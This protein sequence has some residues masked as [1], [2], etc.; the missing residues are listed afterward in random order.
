MM[1][2]AKTALWILRIYND[3]TLDM[4]FISPVKQ[5]S[6]NFKDSC[7]RSE[8]DLIFNVKILKFLFITFPLYFEH[9]SFKS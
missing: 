3:L 6:E 7:L 8:I 4:S 2:I 1:E 9:A 5:H